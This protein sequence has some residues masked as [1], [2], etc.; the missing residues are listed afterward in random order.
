MQDSNKQSSESGVID[1]DATSK[2]TLAD[3]EDE[4]SPDSESAG[5]GRE[6]E[7]PS[8]DGADVTPNKT[9]DIGPM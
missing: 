5:T 3:L 8:P 2:E 9:D 1:S 6:S 4:Q 7:A